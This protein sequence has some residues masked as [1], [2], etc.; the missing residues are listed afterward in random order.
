MIG[1]LYFRVCLCLLSVFAL[2]K[3]TW[4]HVL[5]KFLIPVSTQNEGKRTLVERL[6][7]FHRLGRAVNTE[8]VGQTE[9]ATGSG[10][11][12][13]VKSSHFHQSWKTCFFT[14]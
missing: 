13:L 3:E 11:N 6:L 8:G 4:G 9:T 12:K 7:G 5:Q 1:R 14:G 10:L 2:E